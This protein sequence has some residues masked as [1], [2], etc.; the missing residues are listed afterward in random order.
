MSKGKKQRKKTLTTKNTKPKRK[1]LGALGYHFPMFPIIIS[2]ENG[3]IDGQNRFTVCKEYGLPLEK[4][5]VPFNNDQINTSECIAAIQEI[6]RDQDEKLEIIFEKLGIDFRTQILHCSSQQRLRK[7][8][9][10]KDR[11]TDNSEYWT[12]LRD[13]YISST[14]NRHSQAEIRELFA[15]ERGDSKAIMSPEELDFLKKLSPIITIYR[16]MTVEEYEKGEFGISW[17]L[18]K[19]VA[20]MFATTFAHNY[21]TFGLPKIVTELQIKST[22]IIAYFNDRQEDEILY[23]HNH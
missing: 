5:V 3:I 9:K 23:L 17:T 6:Q 21:D 8:Y 13:A 11:F 14:N 10:F 4:I 2:Q 16:G 22:D 15:A 19:E 7:F 20:E 1:D 18:K 12:E